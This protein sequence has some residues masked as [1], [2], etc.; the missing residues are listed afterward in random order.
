MFEVNLKFRATFTDDAQQSSDKSMIHV[1]VHSRLWITQRWED[2]WS[3]CAS[4]AAR[5]LFVEFMFCF[6]LFLEMWDLGGYKLHKISFYWGNSCGFLS[7]FVVSSFATVLPDNYLAIWLVRQRLHTYILK[8]K[9]QQQKQYIHLTIIVCH[10]SFG[11][12][13]TSFVHFDGWN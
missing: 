10:T 7:L 3:F 11:S 6:V 9:Q 4:P 2:Y 12:H 13:E 8:R 5:M 1:S